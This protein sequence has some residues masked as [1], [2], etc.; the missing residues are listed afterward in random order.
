VFQNS[1]PSNELKDRER[2]N[3]REMSLYVGKKQMGGQVGGVGIKEG[4]YG[5]ETYIN[6]LVK[7]GAERRWVWHL[8]DWVE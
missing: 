5:E 6:G 8:K 3:K 1:Y 4:M 7:L 2:G